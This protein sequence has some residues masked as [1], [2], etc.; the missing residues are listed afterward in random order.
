MTV[1]GPRVRVWDLP[2][3]VFHW[4]LAAAVVAAIATAEAGGAWMAWHG[5]AGLLIIGLLVFRIAWGFIGPE[6]AR[7]RSFAPT[8]AR[9][10]S[11]LRGQWRGLGHNPLGALSVFALLGVLA[12]Q[13]G[14]GL[15]ASDDIAF[16]GPLSHRADDALVEWL[17]GRH[18]LLAKLLFGL[19]GLHLAAIAWHAWVRK[20]KLV[21][22]MLTG[23]RDVEAGAP[24]DDA[25]GVDAGVAPRG[26]TAPAVALVL[27]VTVVSVLAASGRGGGAAPAAAAP[28]P[29]SAAASAVPSW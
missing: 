14:T 4:T 24:L 8:P 25:H 17:T 12:L 15:F 21:G 1:A 16:A 2:L 20:D 5:R 26:R 13:A 27:A 28:G 18:R 9:L 22:P 10:R 29:V 11:Y 7:F 6:T 3:R 23:W 19:A